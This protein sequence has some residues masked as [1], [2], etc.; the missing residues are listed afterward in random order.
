MENI[1][2]LLARILPQLVCGTMVL[3]YFRIHFHK[4]FRLQC[5]QWT[6][7]SGMQAIPAQRFANLQ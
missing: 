2:F 7:G 6:G 5:D 4:D 3:F 1:F